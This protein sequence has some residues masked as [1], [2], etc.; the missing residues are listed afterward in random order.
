V[1]AVVLNVGVSGAT[2][3]GFFA[4]HR[5]FPSTVFERVRFD[6]SR[7]I[8]ALQHCDL[9]M[10]A[11]CRCAVTL[12][13]N[14]KFR[15]AYTFRKKFP[16]LPLTPRQGLILRGDHGFSREKAEAARTIQVPAARSFDRPPSHFRLAATAQI[17]FIWARPRCRGRRE[18]EHSGLVARIVPGS[19]SNACSGGDG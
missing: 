14:R 2:C 1:V 7:V 5:V 19:R 6:P 17:T 10:Q 13:D 11:G 8:K 4:S 3:K 18:A 12:N 9:W 16:T 15:P